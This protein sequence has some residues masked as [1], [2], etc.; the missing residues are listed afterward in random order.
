MGATELCPCLPHA[1]SRKN[2][3]S[4]CTLCFP[5]RP[6]VEGGDNLEI[7]VADKFGKTSRNSTAT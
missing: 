7:R 3:A 6:V 5:N 1:E 2:L 4:A